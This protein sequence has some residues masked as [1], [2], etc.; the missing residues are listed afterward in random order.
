[1]VLFV[2]RSLLA[3]MVKL[4]WLMMNFLNCSWGEEY[5]R[6]LTLCCPA[7]GGSMC[8]QNI[9]QLHYVMLEKVVIVTTPILFA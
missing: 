8:I 4:L 3:S 6:N 7:G 9:G 1:M 2:D 5:P